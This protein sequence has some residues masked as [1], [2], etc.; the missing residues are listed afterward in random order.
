MISRT[1]YTLL[2]K[3]ISHFRVRKY[4][5]HA[6]QCTNDG[7]EFKLQNGNFINAKNRRDIEASYTVEVGVPGKGPFRKFVGHDGIERLWLSNDR[8]GTLVG[9]EV[10][11]DEHGTVTISHEVY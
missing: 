2:E 3:I 5:E 4:C 1:V 10:W 8:N 9:E 6:Q 7:S 11:S